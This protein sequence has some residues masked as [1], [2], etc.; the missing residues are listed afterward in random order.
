MTHHMLPAIGR[1][2][3][4][5]CRNAFLIRE[6]RAVLASYV[7]KRTAITLADLGYVP[8]LEIFREIADRIGCAPAVIDGSDVL[9]APGPMLSQLCAAL[10]IAYSAAMLRWR[11]GRRSTDGVWAPAWYDAVERS[12][13]FAPAV[14]P[15]T[16]Q[17]PAALERI[18]DEAQPYYEALAT[19][20][21]HPAV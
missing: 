16:P 17:L 19:H 12:T 3:I 15:A 4:T 13:G 20:R 7:R 21:L 14:A 18:A 5:Q 1:D 11:P 10:G 2:W 8:Q 9:A 6:P